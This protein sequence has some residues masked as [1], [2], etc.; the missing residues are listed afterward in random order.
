MVIYMTPF[1]EYFT[2]ILLFKY[3]TISSISMHYFQ[4]MNW[5]VLKVDN[6]SD[7]DSSLHFCLYSI[8]QKQLSIYLKIR[9]A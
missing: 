2:V 1:F 9:S 3:M 4:Y 7:L 8:T 5:P 6:F